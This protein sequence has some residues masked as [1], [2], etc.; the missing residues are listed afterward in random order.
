MLC[1]GGEGR[2]ER[3]GVSVRERGRKG[4]IEG[5]WESKGGRKRERERDERVQ[6]KFNIT[7]LL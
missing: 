6:L 2:G 4:E 3:E 7:F 5:R 1:G